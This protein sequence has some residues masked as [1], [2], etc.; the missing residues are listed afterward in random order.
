MVLDEV[1]EALPILHDLAQIYN[2]QPDYYAL[3]YVQLDQA[4]AWLQAGQ[5]AQAREVAQ[6]AIALAAEHRFEQLLQDLWLLLS[7]AHQALAEWQP[8]LQAFQAHHERKLNS[9]MQQAEASARSLAAKLDTERALRESRIDAL[10]GLLN[11]RGFDEALKAGLALASQDAPLTLLLIDMDFFKAVNDRDGH[12]RGDQ[13]LALLG[14]VL[15]GAGRHHDQAARLGGDKFAWFGRLQADPGL[16]VAHQVQQL[17]R[18]E[19][20]ASWPDRPPL[21][22]SI[23]MAQAGEK[24]SPEDRM[25]R[26][27]KALYAAKAA[28]RDCARCD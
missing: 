5:P 7:Q 14:K 21:T 17:L 24:C 27:D 2:A 22:L 12:V 13:A 19:S 6:Q 28:G 25:Q 1:D 23:G 8:A 20:L 11:R 10:T 18:T 4:R 9:A 3:Q 26:A 16:K 15:K